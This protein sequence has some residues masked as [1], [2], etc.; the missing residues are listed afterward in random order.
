MIL[1]SSARCEARGGRCEVKRCEVKR[2]EVRGARCEVQGARGA[3]CEVKRCE[4]RPLCACT[5]HADTFSRLG[6]SI[7]S[8]LQCQASVR[9]RPGASAAAAPLPRGLVVDIRPL[10]AAD[11]PR[12]PRRGL[13]HL[14]DHIVHRLLRWPRRAGAGSDSPHP[15]PAQCGCSALTGSL[16]RRQESAVPASAHLAEQKALPR[17][18]TGCRGPGADAFAHLRHRSG[19]LLSQMRWNCSSVSGEMSLS[20]FH[21]RASAPGGAYCP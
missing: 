16:H 8:V 17:R 12:P 18:R 14:L 7:S 19:A 21:A 9:V 2:C 4:V 20:F 3:R 10:R 5:V 13:L 6:A 15:H 11:H 1:S